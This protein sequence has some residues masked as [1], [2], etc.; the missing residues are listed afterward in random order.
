[1]SNLEIQLTKAKLERL[2]KEYQQVNLVNLELSSIR[3]NA[4]IYQKKTNTNV[5]FFVENKKELKT[6]KKIASL[7]K[8]IFV[9]G[10][11]KVCS[12]A[13][14]QVQ[15]YGIP[16][17]YR[18]ALEINKK[19]FKNPETRNITANLVKRGFLLPNTISVRL[20]MI[21]QRPIK[22]FPSSSSAITN[23]TSK[24]STV[25]T[26][27]TP[28]RLITPNHPNLPI[29]SIKNPTTQTMTTTTPT[30]TPTSSTDSSASSTS[31]K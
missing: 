12:L 2:E 16:R 5:L 1:M 10:I 25:T 31:Q 14:Y 20:G 27:Y 9:L 18:R 6:S 15:M 19:V 26:P 21:P 13:E 29:G 28:S 17:V 22:T 8:K 7:G 24:S 11:A 30:P 23:N 4:S 3:P